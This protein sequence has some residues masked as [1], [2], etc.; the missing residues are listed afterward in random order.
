[1]YTLLTILL[2]LFGI[3]FTLSNS[4]SKLATILVI[5][6]IVLVIC[7]TRF[8][9]ERDES[10]IAPAD[11]INGVGGAIS[12]ADT[13]LAADNGANSMPIAWDGLKFH[14]V[15]SPTVPLISDV[16]IFSPVGDGILL[17]PDINAGKMPPLNG[18]S[19][20]G[21]ASG[22]KGLFMFSHNQTNP[23]CCPSQYSSDTG[24]LCVT[25]EQS[26][27]IASRGGNYT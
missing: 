4:N 18:N 24:C 16:T 9:I 5:L 1:M 26:D 14:A 22:M 11:Y 6:L 23:A 20:I 19:T 8:M 25:K 17:T 3:I 13:R 15:A 2:L 12:T 27:F 7:Y 21:A 10:F